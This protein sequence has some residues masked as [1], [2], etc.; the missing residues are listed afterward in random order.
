MD[1]ITHQPALPHKPGAKAADLQKLATEFEAVFL[2]QMLKS[3]GLGKA[4]TG[5]S[6]GTGED[7]FT[8]FLLA[9]QARAMAQNGGIG[10]AEHIFKSLKGG[11]E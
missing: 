10:L 9:E 4:P 3:A 2:A 7:Q 6:G 11:M 5:F 8:S 1:P